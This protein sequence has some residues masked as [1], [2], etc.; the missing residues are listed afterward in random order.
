MTSRQTLLEGTALQGY[1]PK[2]QTRGKKGTASLHLEGY[3]HMN[4]AIM[5]LNQK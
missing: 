3:A 5:G 2:L 4:A 1:F